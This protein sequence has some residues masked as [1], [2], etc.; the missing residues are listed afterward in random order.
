MNPSDKSNLIVPENNS[1]SIPWWKTP[2]GLWTLGFFFA[3]FLTRLLYIFTLS[4]YQLLWDISATPD[5]SYYHSWAQQIAGGQLSPGRAFFIGPLYAYFLA[6]FYLPFGASLW[7]GRIAQVLLG[8]LTVAL[9]YRTGE[10]A[11]S[12]PAGIIAGILALFYGPMVYADGAYLPITLV[13]FLIMCGL[14]LLCQ[15][16]ELRARGWLAAGLF[17]GFASVDRGNLLLVIPALFILARPLFPDAP[18]PRKRWLHALL[19]LVGLGL[20][21]VPTTL[22]NLIVEGDFIPTSSQGGL[23]FYIGNSPD[24]QGSYYTPQ[25]MRGVPEELNLD[26]SA[27]PAERAVGHKLKPSQVSSFWFDQGMAYIV[28]NFDHIPQLYWQKLILTFTYLELPLNESF[29]FVAEAVRFGPGIQYLGLFPVNLGILLPLAL[30]G[31]FL[32]YKSRKARVLPA[33]FLLYLLS[34]LPFFINNRYRAPEVLPLFIAAGAT[35]TWLYEHIRTFVAGIQDRTPIHAKKL[36]MLG[37]SFAVIIVSAWFI[38]ENPMVLMGQPNPNTLETRLGYNRMYYRMGSLSYNKELYRSACDYYILALKEDPTTYDALLGLAQALSKTDSPKLA[39]KKMDDMLDWSPEARKFYEGGLEYEA[40]GI[41]DQAEA[42]YLLSGREFSCELL[43]RAANLR[44]YDA[45]VFYNLAVAYTSAKKPQEADKAFSQA[46]KLNHFYKYAYLG[47]ITG[48]L[49]MGDLAGTI[50]A[51][52]EGLKVF[53][54]D[55]GMLMVWGQARL[56]QAG[57]EEAERLFRATLNSDP[58]ILG[59]YFNLGE[60]LRL[61]G[62]YEDAL[63]AYKE[64]SRRHP[65]S[66]WSALGLA[67]LLGNQGLEQDALKAYTDY[68]AKGGREPYEGRNWYAMPKK[69]SGIGAEQRSQNE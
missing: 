63:S 28:N 50:A 12:R 31:L 21:L 46:I 40:K 62:K 25:G 3:A 52:Q 42:A 15:S 64:E 56:E 61:Q 68:W 24:A 26:D 37:S 34:M 57:Y 5:S 19:L 48:R 51:A 11:V 45:K 2:E 55:P 6:I 29:Y 13:N 44:P 53:P 66:G 59:G 38:N 14:Y 39:L 36:V 32:L 60:A 54:G 16:D 49:A 4:G 17:L 47:K 9:V 1:S 20:A 65:E 22:H 27:A 10:K 8:A 23:N 43:L 7:A 58:N 67:R 69:L 41:F 33:F 18:T 30:P 35:L